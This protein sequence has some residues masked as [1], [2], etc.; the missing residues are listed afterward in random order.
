MLI[1]NTRR[2]LFQTEGGET[3]QTTSLNVEM[4][5]S[6]AFFIKQARVRDK[7]DGNSNVRVRHSKV[8]VTLPITELG[9]RSR[10]YIHKY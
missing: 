1:P 3:P 4:N 7:H 8:N 6:K 5:I 10:I 9:F 2:L